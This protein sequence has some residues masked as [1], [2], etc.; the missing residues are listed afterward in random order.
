MVSS[1]EAIHANVIYRY[2]NILFMNHLFNVLVLIDFAHFTLYL[3]NFDMNIFNLL[4]IIH[5][6][7]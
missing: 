5:L 1:Y 3:S 6:G 2:L 7:Y 4:Y